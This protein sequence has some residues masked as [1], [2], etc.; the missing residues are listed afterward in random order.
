MPS[1]IWTNSLSDPAYCLTDRQPARPRRAMVFLAR[2][3]GPTFVAIALRLFYLS[4][5]LSLLAGLTIVN[6]H[7]T[8]CAD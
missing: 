3:M 4:G 2:L 5:L 1:R 8:W 6:L 7:N